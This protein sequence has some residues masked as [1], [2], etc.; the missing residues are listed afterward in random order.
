MGVANAQQTE[1]R[2]AVVH[3]GGRVH[4]WASGEKDQFC[5]ADRFRFPHR[6]SLQLIL[7]LIRTVQSSGVVALGHNTGAA[8]D[9]LLTGTSPTTRAHSFLAELQSFE[10]LS[11]NT[12]TQDTK[13]GRPIWCPC[14][15]SRWEFKQSPE[16]SSES[17]NQWLLYGNTIR[18]AD[19][20]TNT[21]KQPNKQ[22]NQNSV[23]NIQK[24]Q[25]QQ[26]QNIDLLSTAHSP[27]GE[28]CRE[29]TNSQYP[30]ASTN[31]GQETQTSSDDGNVNRS[32][33]PNL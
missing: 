13:A 1:G 3:I 4:V 9:S 6:V 7:T 33:T 11:S 23:V 8:V 32:S 26:Q 12:H 29:V 21:K 31:T 14:C 30:T 24:Q 18:A 10:K 22:S 25:Q 17:Q 19:K 2:A 15:I 16:P 28:R 5:S 20:E 27:A